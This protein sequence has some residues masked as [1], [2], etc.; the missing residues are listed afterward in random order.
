MEEEHDRLAEMIAAASFAF[1]H[2]RK[3]VPRLGALRLLRQRFALHCQFEED[4]AETSADD[5][6]DLLKDDHRDLLA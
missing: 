6:V 1:L 5:L 3:P 2:I 4:L